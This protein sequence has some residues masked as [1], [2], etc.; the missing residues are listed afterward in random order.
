MYLKKSPQKGRIYLSIAQSYRDGKTTRTKTIESLGYVDELEKQY[1]DPI[2]H[3]TEVVLRMDAQR[4]ADRQRIDLPL[5]PLKKIDKRTPNKVNL[6]Y[7]VLSRYYH[8]LGIDR[9]WANRR[10]RTESKTN[11]DAVFKLFC[12]SRVIGPDSKKK[13][14]ENKELFLDRMDFSLADAYRSL[15][16]MSHYKQDLVSWIDEK[17]A[18]LKKRDTSSVYYDVTNYYFEINEEDDLRR[19][20]AEKNHRPA[21]LVQMGLLLDREGIPLDYEVFSGNT[22]DCLTML[23][24]LKNMK[25]RHPGERMV[26]VADKGLNTSD[27]IA[28]AIIDGNGYVFSQQVRGANK[29][30]KDW[31]LSDEGYTCNDKRS[32]KIKSRQANKIITTRTVVEGADGQK[33]IEE[34]KV[35]VPVKQ[36]AFW[37]LDYDLRAKEQRL[38]VIEK[39]RDIVYGNDSMASSTAKSKARYV[40]QTAVSSHTGEVGK[41]T[42]SVNEEKIAADEACDGYYC[43]ITS[44]TELEDREIIDLYRGL[45]RI[46]ETFRITKSDLETR[47][48]FLS[49]EERIR[50][51]FMICYVALV[52]LRLIQADLGWTHSAKEIAGDL[53]ACE[54]IAL[55]NNYYVFGHRTDLTDELGKLANVDLSRQYRTRDELRKEIANTKKN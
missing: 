38:Q 44:E 17:I 47:P 22:V 40:K 14:Y 49:R 10:M 53:A 3:F 52:L 39:S 42:L 19:R 12:Y 5:Y 21:P 13:N 23:P 6:G 2:A 24:V 4:K 9:F 15:T 50:T 34:T 25:S 46:E 51:H 7:A 26:I 11:P 54:G 32:F 45:W 27:N 48:V 55:E 30:L 33:H 35:D 43:I 18:G 1:D 31:V 8:M 29:E 20:G 16:F 28:A 37:S 41:I 36:V